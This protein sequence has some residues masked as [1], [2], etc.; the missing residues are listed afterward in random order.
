M[1]PLATHTTFS[2]LCRKKILL[3]LSYLAYLL[4]TDYIIEK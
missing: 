2:H 4:L 1:L 3:K